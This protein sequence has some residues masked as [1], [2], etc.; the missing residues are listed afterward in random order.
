MPLWVGLIWYSAVLG[1]TFWGLESVPTF[2]PWTNNL[3]KTFSMFNFTGL[4][5]IIGG[6]MV[7]LSLVHQVT[8]K[9]YGTSQ[10][11]LLQGIVFCCSIIGSN[12]TLRSA[13]LGTSI[14]CIFAGIFLRVL[15]R[16][17]ANWLKSKTYD[18]EFFI[19]ISIVL[20]AVNFRGLGV[21]GGKALM[22]SWVETLLILPLI[23]SIG[24]FA[25]KMN[26]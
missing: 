25:L 17:K 1:Y 11:L 21:V 7:S 13:G 15:L 20:L 16:R 19:K 26:K 9:P 22:V 24:M 18:L 23:F 4:I 3:G 12:V 8:G 6:V 5:L 14:W 10:Y 2:Y